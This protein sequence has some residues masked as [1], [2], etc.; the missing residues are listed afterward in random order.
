MVQQSP[1]RRLSWRV[2][3]RA[4]HA[5]SS[6]FSKSMPA[7]S[8][9]RGVRVTAGV[10]GHKRRTLARYSGRD[11]EKSC[12]SLLGD[13]RVGCVREFGERMREFG[14]RFGCAAARA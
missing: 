6:C 12:L 14:G 1:D 4:A 5:L 3:V 7:N 10:C 8:P 9:G 2:R 13:A 11:H